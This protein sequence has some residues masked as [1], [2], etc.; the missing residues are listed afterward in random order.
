[1]SA[2]ANSR[3]LPSVCL[4]ALAGA[5]GDIGDAPPRAGVENPLDHAGVSCTPPRGTARITALGHVRYLVVGELHGTAET[6]AVFAELVCAVARE[7]GGR[8]LV[9]LEFQEDA[10]PAFESYVASRGTAADRSALLEESGWLDSARGPYPD[11][12]T[13]EAMLRMVE[14]LR[15][16]R[17]AG[18]AIS[19]TTFRRPVRVVS[20]SQ[21]PY[22]MDMADSLRDAFDAGAYDT[23]IVL[24]GGVHARRTTVTPPN[25]PP[26]EPMAMHLPVESTLTLDALA[27]DGEAWNCQ[28]ATCGIHARQGHRSRG[29]AGLELGADMSPGYDGVIPIGPVT[30]S[31]PVTGRSE[32]RG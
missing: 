25:R 4:A 29:S 23:V 6:P 12:R 27:G 16:L 10:R 5:C 30:A 26:F 15:V 20:D 13:S 31:P 28:A 24:V 2:S 18:L 1:M 21:T 22:E 3:F 19:V 14:R 11:G 32:D 17:A 7:R 8:L 9:G